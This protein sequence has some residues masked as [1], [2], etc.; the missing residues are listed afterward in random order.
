MDF[1]GRLAKSIFEV[2]ENY[3]PQL[4]V[5][6]T[7]PVL[8]GHTLS[9]LPPPP[10]PTIPAAAH[11]PKIKAAVTGIPWYLPPKKKG[12]RRK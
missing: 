2:S 3:S 1:A 5:I 9:P 10:A 11:A 4:L 7:D 8:F 6:L 12:S